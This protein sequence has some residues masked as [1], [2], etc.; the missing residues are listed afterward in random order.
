MVNFYDLKL[1]V[2]NFLSVTTEFCMFL[3]CACAYVIFFIILCLSVHCCLRPQITEGMTTKIV[4]SGYFCSFDLMK[5][6]ILGLLSF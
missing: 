2:V 3:V 1:A 5:F 4:F 6:L